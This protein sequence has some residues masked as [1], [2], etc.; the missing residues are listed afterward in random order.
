[1]ALP[2][3]S[4]RQLSI[5]VRKHGSRCGSHA[6]RLS[7]SQPINRSHCGSQ[8][9]LVSFEK[10]EF[11]FQ[12]VLRISPREKESENPEWNMFILMELTKVKDLDNASQSLILRAS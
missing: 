6:R 12:H 8:V 2:F 5:E 3:S 11:G 9:C 4:V 10:G 1:V 7:I